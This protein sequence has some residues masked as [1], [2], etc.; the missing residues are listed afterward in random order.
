MRRH[1][2]RAICLGSPSLLPCRRG[3]RHVL[4]R[5]ALNR[6]GQDVEH[7]LV[8]PES[9]LVGGQGESLVETFESLT[10]ILVAEE[11][12]AR[13]LEVN[14]SGTVQPMQRRISSVL[15]RNE[16]GGRA[17]RGVAAEPSGVRGTVSAAVGRT[18]EAYGRSIDNSKGLGYFHWGGL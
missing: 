7:A 13:R 5:R 3:S 6:T 4:S 10:V 16:A 12:V 17:E 18:R 15:T 11:S 2:I 8:A 14:D 1:M 9:V